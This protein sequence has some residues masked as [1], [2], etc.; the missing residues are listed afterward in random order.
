MRLTEP[1]RRQFLQ[2]IGSGTFAAAATVLRADDTLVSGTQSALLTAQFDKKLSPK[3]LASLTDK[4]ERQWYKGKELDLIGVPVGGLFAGQVY[5][6]GDGKLWHW[7]IF[8][9][10]YGTEDQHYAKPPT[11]NFPFLQSFQ[12]QYE[13]AGK[14]TR[15]PLDR[16]GFSNISFCG[17]YPVSNVKYSDPNCPLSVL[18]TA[19]SPFIPLNS[20]DSSLPATIMSYGI[21]NT[22]N[23]PLQ[24][25]ISGVMENAIC[26]HNRGAQGTL[27]N[28]VVRHPDRTTLS[29]SAV[30][31]DPAVSTAQL[32]RPEIVFEDWHS[33]K[34]EGWTT[35]GNAFGVGPI[36]KSKIPA[37]QG[38]VGGDS[39]RVV[40]S[41]ATA[42][43]D[44]VTN[45]DVATGTLTSRPFEIN[46]K[47]IRFWIGGGSH[48]GKTCVNLIVN[49]KV[50]RTAV[51]KNNNQMSQATFETSSLE[52]K[53][54]QIQ[55]VDNES[56]AWGNIGI[57]KIVFTDTPLQ[58]V[59]LV[60]LP[61]FGE[62]TLSV[63]G[64]LDVLGRPDISIQTTK[65]AE[66][67]IA[68][69]LSDNLTGTVG[70][71]LL[72]KP[73]Q[74]AEVTFVITW[75]FPNLT[76]EGLGL[77]GRHYAIRYDSADAIAGYIAANFKR[78]DT[79]TKDWWKT[80]YQSS[81]PH[82]FLDRSFLNTSV[83]ATSTILRFAN[84]RVW[85]W[86]GVGCGVGTC[87]HV[88]HYAQAMG[89]LFPDIERLI[90]EKVDFGIAFHP[91]SGVIGFRAEFDQSMAVD[92][93][94]GTLLRAYRE[95]LMSV[96]AS[97]LRRNWLKIKKAY[98]PLLKLDVDQDGIL[99]GPQM[100]TLDQPWYGQIA[101]LSGLHIAA[102][103]AG[104]K[105]AREMKD[106]EFANLC[107]SNADT[108]ARNIDDRLFN[109][110]Y[111]YQIAEPK[112]KIS[113]GSFDGCEIDQVLGDSWARQVGLQ[114]GIRSGNIKTALKSIYKYNFAP[115][116]GP[117][118]LS[119][120]QG[121]WFAMPGEGG[122]L[123]CS[124]PH[125][126]S[127]RQ[128]EGFD[129]YFNEC[130]TGFEHQV[131]GHMIWEG[132]ITEGLAVERAIH[133]RYHPLRR[134]PWN[135]VEYGDHYAR[136]MASYGVFLAACG[137]E[138]NGPS[139][140]IA[141]APKLNAT[142][143]TAAF[144]SA[145]AWG[146]FA[147]IIGG[148]KQRAELS[149]KYG[150]LTLNTFSLTSPVAIGKRVRAEVDG[151]QIGATMSVDNNRRTIKFPTS[152]ELIAGRTLTIEIG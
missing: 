58:N 140:H 14:T 112:V 83:L 104:E 132:L 129:F 44:S 59:D 26:L 61:D 130:M 151:R 144:T 113:V 11:P 92:G 5:L 75:F 52:G 57:G 117:F 85:A 10:H 148:T 71:R 28:S 82:W 149:I 24:I 123:M 133:D 70:K 64:D 76:I 53:S 150:Q 7:D 87:T 69:S 67:A 49:G 116:V 95:H 125:G 96:D 106:F 9:K 146:R 38:N 97:F 107:K 54:A 16:T 135:E 32:P 152:V 15:R 108:G 40:N 131:A 27:K 33:E 47:F 29:C 66:T 143:F 91:D 115:D 142:N 18:L 3:W 119:H 1:T 114:T 56:G 89:R 30:K 12:V 139:G 45:K 137:F 93:Q 109:G 37:Y 51:G 25:T 68:K 134:N 41:H 2:I 19:Y 74:I 122:L 13:S 77:V 20:D 62:M 31:I 102:L 126:E 127:A 128:Q 55:I 100:N 23:S 8:N 17:E 50:V 147:Q 124:W 48:E 35:T 110:E 46:R 21:T 4:G 145:E 105:M 39:D 80:W 72:L 121:R 118:R 63:L 90:R 34:Y 79:Q 88:W 84:G 42:P 136:S 73:G 6:G 60:R 98:E 99:D 36:D 120:K 81:L 86:E 65:P 101:W 78:L 111:Y 138:Y 43:G 94:T 22:G 141:F 103:R